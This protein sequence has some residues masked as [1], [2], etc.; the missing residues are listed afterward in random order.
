MRADIVP[1]ATF[2]DYELPDHTGSPRRLSEVQRDDPLAL[3]LARGG[4]CPKEHLRHVWMAAMEPEVAVGYC[5]F[6]TVSTDAV[7]ESHEWRQRLGAHWPFLSDVERVV[8]Q[9]LE[10]PEYTDPEH[11]L[12]IPHTVLLEPGLVIYRIY[13][14]YWYWGRP[15]PD[16]MRLDFRALTQRCRPDWDLSARGLREAWGKGERERF[17]PYAAG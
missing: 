10:I 7:L 5:R 6:V 15:T 12:M 4:Y 13:L 1:G 3:V 8:Q 14:A 17:Y 2:P 11:D 16:E 9:D